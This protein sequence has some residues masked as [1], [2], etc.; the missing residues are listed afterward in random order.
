VDRHDDP[1]PGLVRLAEQSLGGAIVGDLSISQYGA[2]LQ[3]YGAADGSTRS[4]AYMP[5]SGRSSWQNL[6]G[7]L[8]TDPVGIRSGQSF[9]VFGEAAGGAMWTDVY[10]PGSGWSGWQS[11]GGNLH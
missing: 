10:T 9:E 8:A 1:R 11:L 3:V 5:P 7:V 4:I 2:Q 6:G